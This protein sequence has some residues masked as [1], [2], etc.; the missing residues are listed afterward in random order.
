MRTLAILTALA[1][2]LSAH[3]ASI[4]G[5]FAGNGSGLTNLSLSSISTNG[6]LVGYALGYVSYGNGIEWIPISS[7]ATNLPISAMQTNGFAPL[8]VF[9]MKSDGSGFG[10]L[11]QSGGGVPGITGSGS[12]VVTTNGSGVVNIN[13][14]GSGGS[15]GPDMILHAPSGPAIMKLHASI[16][17]QFSGVHP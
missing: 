17:P 9:G 4:V 10:P 3:A 5:N 12:A 13:V 8:Q 11:T 14:T 7:V 1:M 6:A 15:S 16:G 2:N